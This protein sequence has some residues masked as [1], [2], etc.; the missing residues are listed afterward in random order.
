[1]LLDRE[2]SG[3]EAGVVTTRD[4]APMNDRESILHAAIASDPCANCRSAS[5]SK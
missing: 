4:T 1:M 5:L 3:V 2:N